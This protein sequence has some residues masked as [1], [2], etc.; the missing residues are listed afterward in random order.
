MTKA[1]IPCCGLG[2]RMNMEFY[3]SKE[4][5]LNPNELYEPLIHWTINRCLDNNIEPLILVRKEKQDLISYLNDLKIEY[6]E[7]EPGKEW[8]ETVYNSKDHWSN[9]NILILPDTRWKPESALKDIKKLLDFGSE[10][11]FGVHNV[12]DQSKWGWVNKEYYCEKSNIQN[13]GTV[14]GLIGFTKKTGRK[15]FY[16]MQNKGEIYNHEFITNFVFLDEFKDLTRTGK[17]E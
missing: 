11:V 10:V 2:L 4:M 8:A 9:Q 7:M 6:I 1:I 17:I 12:N 14:W 3:E 5:I 15:L 13:P 16:N